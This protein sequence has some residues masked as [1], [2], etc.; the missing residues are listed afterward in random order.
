MIRWIVES[1]L[2]FHGLVIAIA[3]GVMVFGILQLRDAPVD[4]LPEFTPPTVEI[5]TEA[6]GLSAAEV[7]Q[8]ITVPLEQD[9]LNTVAFVDEIRSESV[10]GLS[11]VTLIFEEGTDLLDARQVVQE[12][13][14]QAHGLPNVSQPPQMLQPLSSTN[15]VMMIGLSSS[16]LSLIDLSVLARWTI[17]PRLMGVQGV[18]NVAVWGQRERQLQVR[19][20]PEQLRSDGVTLQQIVETTGNALFVSPLSFVEASTP[21]TGGFIDTPNQRLQLRHVS[22][23]ITADDLAQVRVAGTAYRLEDVASVVE[24]HPPLIG[25]AVT[26]DGSG[27]LLVVEKLPASNTLAVTRG[28]EEAMASLG[29]GLPGV[30]TDATVFRPASFIETSIDNL[31]VALIIA[32]ALVLLALGA[33]FFSWRSVVVGAITIPLAVVAAGLVLYVLDETINAIVLAGLVAAL[34]IVIDDAI[35]AAEAIARHVRQHRQGEHRKSTAALVLDASLAMRSPLLFA[36]LI[37]LLAVAPLFFL[38]GASGAFFADCIA[39]TKASAEFSRGPADREAPLLVWLWSGYGWVLARVVQRPGRT[40]IVVGAIVVAGV[41]VSPFLRQ[42][43][44]LPT[45]KEP[46]LLIEWEAPAGAS[47]RRCCGSPS[48]LDRSSKQ[49]RAC[50]ASAST[51]VVRSLEIRSS[52]SA[53]ARY[54]SASIRLPTTTGRSPRCSRP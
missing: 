35:V 28:V 5:Q 16:E 23:I 41:A 39:S 38:A 47:Q 33:F 52:A 20:D 8:L 19:V 32:A 44:L 4:T 51:S 22:P 9:L 48:R 18:A 7:E 49:S 54:G 26:G 25:D 15:R 53:P 12:Q 40:L 10:A 2:R 30:E 6:L 13:L 3:A 29:P 31:T 24:D 37:L 45:F 27:L 43:S 36:T 46:D 21:G 34:L 1:S 42:D 11:S 17:R 50:E 14:T